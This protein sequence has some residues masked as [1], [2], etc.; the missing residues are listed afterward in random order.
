MKV[1]IL[2]ILFL[3]FLNTFF[4]SIF[5]K[6]EYLSFKAKKGDKL[7]KILSLYHLPVTNETKQKFAELNKNKIDVNFKLFW[8][9]KYYLPVLIVES[10][11][12]TKFL[13]D[14]VPRVE[15]EKLKQSIFDYT[16]LLQKQ[17][18]PFPK[19]AVLIPFNYLSN[20]FQA[21]S[22]DEVKQQ[23]SGEDKL[24][25]KE[26]L[27]LFKP[28]YGKKYQKVKVKS[29]KL[30]SCAFYLVSGHGGPDPGAIGYFEGKELHE[31][32]YAYD[33]TLR[34][35]RHLEENGA[36]V[37]MITIDTIDGIRDDKFL[38]NSNREIFYGGI[39]IPLNQKER[40]QIC[41]NIVNKL[42]KINQKKK[43]HHIS[44]NIHLDSRSETEK[45]DVFFYY[46]EQ[47]PISQII[48]NTL[49]KTLEEQYKKH[50]PNRIYSGTVET[51]NLFMLNNSLPT[52]VYIE[53][54]NIKN[55]SN[56][57]RFIENTNREALAKWLT[58]G[59][60]NYIKKRQIKK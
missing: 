30:K 51:R 44:L 27:K 38:E 52:T 60:I 25:S 40:L 7:D 16:K 39:S 47:N 35:A 9:V 58:I 26:N 36:T 49:Q 4:V 59:I 41:A 5:S 8:G 53:L 37:Y 56:Q 17:G 20:K 42:Y 12:L 29:R 54:G 14:K 28:Y 21:V 13:Q 23:T 22:K 45:V 33:I 2:S 18:V 50:Q 6:E 24:K 34:L 48:A 55:R 1:K 19:S 3:I 31:D 46:Q 32:E 11:N 57:F 10:K 15:L 43:K